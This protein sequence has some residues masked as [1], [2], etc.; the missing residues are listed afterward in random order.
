[1]IDKRKIIGK[2]GEN[3]AKNYLIKH[4]HIIKHQNITFGHK[5]ID[6]VSQKNKYTIFIE[7]K[8]RTSFVLGSANT[9]LTSKQIKILKKAI[10]LYAYKYKIDKNFIRLDL[11]SVD[12][13]KKSKIAKIQH[14]RDIF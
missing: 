5:E 13:N 12:I 11:I 8:T 10:S 6:I 7:V 4:G 9:A 2:T 1:M 14:F 3:I